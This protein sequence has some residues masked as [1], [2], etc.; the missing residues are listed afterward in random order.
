MYEHKLV[1]IAGI[2]S[3]SAV[4]FPESLVSGVAYCVLGATLN[5]SLTPV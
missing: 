1:M 3:S 5:H 4:D 2:V